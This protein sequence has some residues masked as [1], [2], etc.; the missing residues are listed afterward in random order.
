MKTTADNF[1]SETAEEFDS[2]YSKSTVFK[3]R[4]QVWS[5]L[6]PEY[7]PAEGRVLDLGCGSGVFSF[8]LASRGYQVTGIDG[9][10]NM[11]AICNKR[12]KESNQENASF[13]LSKIPFDKSLFDIKFDVVISSSVLEYIEDMDKVLSDVSS[14]LQTNGIFMVSM[15]NSLALYR[16]LERLAWNVIRRPR[17]LKY[18]NHV[19]NRDAFDARVKGFGFELLHSQYYGNQSKLF[20]LLPDSAASTLFVSIFKKK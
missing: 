6:W 15:P 18:V 20:A 9:A 7:L 19:V 5:S 3:E 4:Y 11:I 1:F 17:Y 13:I 10:E 8:A 2:G 16:K 12:K 14:I